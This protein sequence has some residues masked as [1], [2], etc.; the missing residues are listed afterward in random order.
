MLIIII[1]TLIKNNLLSIYY[2]PETVLSIIHTYNLSAHLI[3]GKVSYYPHLTSKGTKAHWGRV[4]SVH[5]HSTMMGDRTRTRE[6]PAKQPLESVL[7]PLR[8]LP[9]HMCSYLFYIQGLC[10][11]ILFN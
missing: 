10:Y 7:L 11:Q 4:L 5:G 8:N 9:Y 3:T 6:S 1:I 2:I